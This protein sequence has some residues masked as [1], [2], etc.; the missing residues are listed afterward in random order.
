MYAFQSIAL[1][2]LAGSAFATCYF[3]NGLEDGHKETDTHRCVPRS[4]GKW[5]FTM[6]TSLIEVPNPGQPSGTTEE[7]ISFN[8]YDAKCAS[9][10][11]WS[12]PSCGTPYTMRAGVTPKPLV[13]NNIFADVGSPY[14][15]IT[16]GSQSVTATCNKHSD[17]LRA[18]SDCQAHFKP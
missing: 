6:E 13:V 2:S 17:G 9:R 8:I 4:D 18:I 7:T 12:K 11:G 1:A 10:A 5:T 16:Y 14:M 15:H 3:S